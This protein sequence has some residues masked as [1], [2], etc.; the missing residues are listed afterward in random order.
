M[1]SG[2]EQQEN[3]TLAASKDA[4]R[5]IAYTARK[6]Q[7]HKQDI[8]QQV[9]NTLIELPQ[10][11][12]AQTVMWYL[13]TGTEL[14]TRHVLPAVLASEKKIVIPYCVNKELRL[15]LLYSLDELVPGSY[16]ILEP[17]KDRWREHARHMEIVELDVIVIPG[18]GFDRRGHRLGHG[19]GY[20]DKLLARA[21]PQT[22]LVGLCYQSQVFN[23][24][25]VGPKD[26]N[27]HMLITEKHIYTF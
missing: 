5:L 4:L 3:T 25:P 7:R 20:Y 19:Q 21:D 16:G 24:I 1:P 22:L 6:N 26:V 17:P 13:D 18:L 27:M 15:W 11:H 2:K 8:S 23:E 14:R 9:C 10:Y 12:A